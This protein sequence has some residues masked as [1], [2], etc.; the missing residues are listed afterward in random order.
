M[1][2]YSAP[3]I[4]IAFLAVPYIIFFGEDEE[5]QQYVQSFCSFH[6]HCIAH[7]LFVKMTNTCTCTTTRKK[8]KAKFS[9]WTFPVL[10]DGPLGVVSAAEM[11]GIILFIVFVLSALYS[12]TVANFE[13]LPSYG[14]DLTE[15]EKRCNAFLY[16]GSGNIN[17]LF[18]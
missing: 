5:L 14:D 15:G 2:L 8:K 13:M 1:L 16:N 9:L 17:Q 12:Y 6:L 3:I 7:H 11:I 18:F 10:V 4:V